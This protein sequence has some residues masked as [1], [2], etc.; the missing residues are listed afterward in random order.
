MQNV[1]NTNAASY[2]LGGTGGSGGTFAVTTSN[3]HDLNNLLKSGYASGSPGNITVTITGLTPGQEYQ[4]DW[5]VNSMGATARDVSLRVYRA[6][7]TTPLTGSATFR[8]AGQHGIRHSADVHA[9]RHVGQGQLCH[10]IRIGLCS[11][12][13]PSPTAPPLPARRA[14]CWASIG[15]HTSGVISG[16]AVTLTV[17]DGTDVTALNPTCTVSA[18]ATVSPASGTTRNFTDPQTY[19]VTAQNGITEKVYTV[20]VAFSPVSP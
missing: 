13:S 20:T 6:D 5:L 14:T 15:A 7:G 18:N 19:T 3:E 16:T 2:S 9:R 8:M 1:T 11:T 17:P 12:A 10:P 4:M